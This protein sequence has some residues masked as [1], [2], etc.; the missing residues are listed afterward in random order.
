MQAR[1]AGETPTCIPPR[2]DALALLPA[3]PSHLARSRT[4][5]AGAAFAL[6]KARLCWH[7]ELLWPLARKRYYRTPRHSAHALLAPNA[8]IVAKT[9]R[10]RL[11]EFA[12][13]HALGPKRCFPAHF[14]RSY[15]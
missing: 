6:R 8:C 14:L 10:R 1:A 15:Q 2:C 3:S 11:V 4:A 5:S 12:Q 7:R 9:M 13:P